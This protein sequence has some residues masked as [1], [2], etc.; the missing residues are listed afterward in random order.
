MAKKSVEARNNKRMRKVSANF[1]ARAELRKIIKKSSDESAREDALNMLHS[2]D[3][4]ASY[5]RVR[6]RCNSCG[7]SRGVLRK[8]GICRICLR[9]AFCRGDVPGLKKA[10]W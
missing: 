4:N 6:R 7:R 9:E 10:S 5:V 8:F 2:R 1:A 3:R